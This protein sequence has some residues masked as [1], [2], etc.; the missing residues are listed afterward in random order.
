MREEERE[1]ME[2]LIGKYI[3]GEANPQEISEVESW[4]A[5][6]PDNQKYLEDTQLIYEKAQ[7]PSEKEFNAEK[8]WGAVLGQINS[9]KEKRGLSFSLWKI[10]ASLA[11]L[12]TISFVLYY[13]MAPGEE[14][15][16]RAEN[17]ISTQVFPDQTEISLN[18]S[19]AATVKYNPRKKTGSIQLTGEATIDIGKEKNIQWTVEVENLLIRDIGTVFH[20]KAYPEENSIEVSVLEGI[21]EMIKPAGDRLT[22]QA[23]EK[24]IYDKRSGEFDTAL[25]DTN[26]VA[27]KTRSFQ[28]SEQS[29]SEVVALV[30]E[31]YRQKIRL[32]GPI[33]DCKITVGFENEDLD[34]I[35]EILAE[36]MGLEILKGSAEIVLSGDGCF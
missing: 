31:V 24:G 27:F 3:L 9:R 19:S 30:S 14:Y 1:Y 23:G 25:A 13:Q 17:E 18:R 12:A 7:L 6:H 2:D 4:C 36:T 32:A 21:V 11:L 22:L 29:L 5:L 15:L 34:T 33:G 20:V 16:L 10:A 8:A 26:V 35:L 28:F